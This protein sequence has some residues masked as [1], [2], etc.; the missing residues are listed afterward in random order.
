[1]FSSLTKKLS[2]VFEKLS[3]KK[4]ITENDIDIAIREIRISLLEADVNLEVIKQL[5]DKLKS[6]IVGEKI[7]KGVNPVQ[8]II[9]IVN[10][11]IVKILGETSADLHIDPSQLNIFLIVGLQGSGKTTSAAKLAKYLFDKYKLNV[12]TASS[13]VYRPFGREQLETICSQNNI[14]TLPIIFDEAPIAIAKRALDFAKQ[15]KFNALVF[16]TAGRMQI[17]EN[18]M[19]EICDIKKILSPNNTII[20]LDSMVGQDGL[21]ITKSFNDK[22]QLTGSILTKIDSDSRSGIALSLKAITNIPIQF[23][24]VSEKI[25][26]LEVFHPDRIAGRIL[27]MGDIVSLV[28][29]AQEK[30]DEKA[31]EQMANKMFSGDFDLNDMLT[32]IG[33]MKKMG[34]ISGIMKFLPGMGRI[35]DA[36]RNSGIND[37][38]FKYQEAIIL[39]MTQNERKHPEI[40]FASRKKRI[41]KG[42]GTTIFEVDKLLKQFEKSKNMMKQM[43]KMGGL[44]GM[45]DMMKKMQDSGDLPNF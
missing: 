12:L 43:Q 45:M 27:G 14:A 32:Q 44:S 3:L 18:L 28:E 1:V 30:I 15:N 8:Q 26:G 19:N 31:A 24:G 16:D 17:D 2:S 13:D 10:D 21:N 29:K 40:I 36:I 41:A 4:Y 23:L 20:V 42:S 25:D 39:S 38:T 11:E 34:S 37:D 22:L 7:L 9:K 5:T 35:Q 33:Q 6:S